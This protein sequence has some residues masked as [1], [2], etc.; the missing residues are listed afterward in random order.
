MSIVFTRGQ[1]TGTDTRRVRG[2]R[3]RAAITPATI[4]SGLVL[5]IAIAWALFPG[6]FTHFDPNDGGDTLPFW[7]RASNIGS[8]PT[9][10][11]AMPSPASS[12]APPSPCWPRSWPSGSG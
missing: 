5:L 12:T 10:P 4:A 2:G 8:A 9:R 1:G 11:A 6:L 3:A 7:P